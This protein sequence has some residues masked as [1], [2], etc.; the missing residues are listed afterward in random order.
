MIKRSGLSQASASIGAVILFPGFIVY[1][2]LIAALG[3]EPLLGG[4]FAPVASLLMALTLIGTP[5]WLSRSDERVG[6]YLYVFIAFAVYC[7]LWS[8]MWVIRS[9]SYY[10][11]EAY[12][13]VALTFLLLTSLFL[14]GLFVNPRLYSVNAILS[15]F[16]YGLFG[17][18]IINGVLTGSF[19]FNARE[20][21]GAGEEVATYQGFATSTLI[22]AVLCIAFSRTT[23][24]KFVKTGV[25]VLCL[26]MLGSRSEMIGFAVMVGALCATIAVR[27][28]QGAVM[29]VALMIILIA[30]GVNYYYVI[31]SGRFSELVDLGG[32]SSLLARQYYSDMAILQ[33]QDS[34][35]FGIP[36]G[37]FVF[38]DSGS[39]AHSMLSAWVSFGLVGFALY[40]YL[41][42]VPFFRSFSEFVLKGNSDPLWQAVFM[43]SGIVL[44]LCLLSKPVFWEVPGLAWGLFAQA[45]LRPSRAVAGSGRA[46]AAA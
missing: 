5:S 14:I 35:F 28:Y 18:L 16:L 13:Q 31:M 25:A 32:S 22:V 34:P 1:H 11:S 4:Y 39:Y 19:E 45:V 6:A 3:L 40:L 10:M 15:G 46:I 24:Q 27:S 44:L 12:E 41:I 17:F 29:L 7:L 37:H 21:F 26:L 30:L 38:G 42:I 9:R 33:I 43:L 20:Q 2:T 23:L 36:G 8:T